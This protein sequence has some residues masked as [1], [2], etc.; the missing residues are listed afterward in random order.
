MEIWEKSCNFAATKVIMA[1][2]EYI[3][4]LS[5][6][7]FWDIDMQQLDIE[8]HA[9]YLIQRV[10]EYGTLDDW[11][12]T[13][14]FYGLDKV[15][16]ACKQMRTLEPTALSFIC[17]ISDTKPQEYRCYQF[18]QSFPTLWNS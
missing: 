1:T 2:K 12:L 5:Q 14:D 7:L 16:A 18:K 17:A 4:R 8:Q 15:V 9:P 6:Y 10:L 11:R 13:R 3:N